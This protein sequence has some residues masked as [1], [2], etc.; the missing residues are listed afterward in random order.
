MKRRPLLILPLLGLAGCQTEQKTAQVTPNPFNNPTPVATRSV[1]NFPQANIETAA[2]VDTLGRQI[3]AANREIGMR[4]CFSAIGSPNV[5]VFHRGT[6]Q[7]IVTEGLVKQCRSDADLAA[8]L[9]RELG[10]MV[11]EREALA[12]PEMRTPERR[13]PMQVPVGNGVGATFGF[14]DDRTQLVELLKYEQQRRQANCLPP[15]PLLLARKYLTRTG[16]SEGALDEAVPLF[17]TADRNAGFEKQMT[18]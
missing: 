7:V 3:L 17:K 12:T 1:S 8:V 14:D 9:C 2:R 15:D 4:P 10:K 6:S 18:R 13:P 5:E 16:F 11:A